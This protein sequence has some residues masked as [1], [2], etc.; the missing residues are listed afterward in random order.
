MPKQRS[1]RRPKRRF[2]GNQFSNSRPK[3]TQSDTCDVSGEPLASSSFVEF[4]DDIASMSTEK[5]LPKPADEEIKI[6]E[7]NKGDEKGSSYVTGYRLVDMEILSS[8]ISS[9]RCADCGFLTLTLNENPFHRS[10]CASCLRI[11]CENCGWKNEFFSSKKQTKSFEVNRRLVYT[12][13]SLGKGHSGAKKFCTLMNMPPPSGAKPFQKSSNTIKKNI[14][15]IAKKSMADAAAEIRNANN[16]E[17]ND[18]VNCP[19]SCD[20][21]WQKRGFS[22]NN[23]CVA[24]ISIDTG[25]VLDA[26]AMSKCCKRCELHSHLDKNSVEY[27]LFWADHSNNCPANYKGSAPA[28]EPEG[29]ER[30]FRR[31]AETHRLRYSEL[32]GDGESKSYNKVKDVYAAAGIEVAKQE[33]IGHVQKR[34]GTALRKLKKDTPGL[35]GKGKLTDSMIDK[36]QNYY[37]IA[38]RSNV[39]DLQGMKKAVLA[40]LF[41]CASSESRHLHDYCPIGANSWCGYH[42]DRANYKHGP[43]LPLEVIAKVKPVYQR[44]SDDG[45]LQ[46]CLH[47]KTQNRNERLNGL[48]WQRVPKEVFVGRDVLKFGLFDA[49]AHFNV[50]AQTVL[51]LY[52]ALG[53][54]SG[55]YTEEGCKML[56]AEHAYNALY[57]GEEQNKKQRKVLRGKKKRKEDKN[58]QSEGVTYATGQF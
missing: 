50:G 31:S 16:A 49:V 30:I 29:T 4:E 3:S 37:G 56:D 25:K 12:M 34:V 6:G 26:E 13:R 20:G 38:I 19:V 42:R 17:E 9:L 32:Y 8:V 24:V 27:Q 55:K 33:C 23:G 43:G 39:G 35:S 14:K 47:G 22:S 5:V 28:M 48:V 45:L 41:H 2:C 15:A 58:K 52:G 18:M 53:I 44:L 36:L 7:S 1:L 21:T 10:G 40:S 57:K 11:F 54:P 46:K 51:Q